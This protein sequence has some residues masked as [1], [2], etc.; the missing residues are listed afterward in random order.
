MSD[1]HR[2]QQKT[3]A[4]KSSNMIFLHLKYNPADPSSSYIQK[5]WREIVV[6]PK[7]KPHITHLKNYLGER[8]T[9]SRLVIAYS[10]HLN[11]GN[12]LSYRKICNRPGLKVSSYLWLDMSKP[13]LVLFKWQELPPAALLPFE[14]NKVLKLSLSCWVFSIVFITI[15]AIITTIMDHG[16]KF[17]ARH[18]LD[19]GPTSA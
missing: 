18:I 8:F 7:N 9:T 13:Y 10:R 4:Q 12:L 2:L 15:I 19:L 17:G 1:E 16:P 6:Q 14:K 5:L 3:L 11:I